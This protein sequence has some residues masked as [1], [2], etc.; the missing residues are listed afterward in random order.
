LQGTG[1]KLWLFAIEGKEAEVFLNDEAIVSSSTYAETKDTLLTVIL[2]VMATP[3][4]YS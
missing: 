2:E 4:D 3:P 1:V